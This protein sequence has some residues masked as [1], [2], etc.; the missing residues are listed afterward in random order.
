MDEKPKRKP[1]RPCEY[2]TEIGIQIC[3]K[4]A[5]RVPVHVICRERRMPSEK[6]VYNWLIEFEDFRTRYILARERAADKFA[7]EIIEL[8]DN[9]DTTNFR[10]VEKAKLQVDARK[11]AAVKFAPKKYGER[12][13]TEHSGGVELKTDAEDAKQKLIAR[14]AK[15][16]TKE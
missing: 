7:H 13:Q 10:G 16:A 1:G 2:T 5:D 6:T 15:R 9:A 4:I 12:I 14:L 3:E 11:W 8:A